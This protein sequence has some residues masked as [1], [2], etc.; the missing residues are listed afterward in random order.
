MYIVTLSLFNFLHFE[1][2]GY[3]IFHSA[4]LAQEDG[5]R[6]SVTLH[7][8][9]PQD[10]LFEPFSRVEHEGSS[11]Q[12]LSTSGDQVRSQLYCGTL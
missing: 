9:H 3:F 10:S 7:S 4:C 11:G 2:S 6:Q 8:C 1:H 5:H 12:Q